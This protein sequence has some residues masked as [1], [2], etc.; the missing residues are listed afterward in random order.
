M[1]SPMSKTFLLPVKKGGK[2]SGKKGSQVV[3][4]TPILWN[5]R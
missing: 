1:R 4:L 2:K 5:K 3:K